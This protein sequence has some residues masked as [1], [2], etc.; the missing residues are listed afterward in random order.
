MPGYV[1]GYSTRAV[2]QGY[3]VPWHAAAGRFARLHVLHTPYMLHM[4][5]PR[6][7]QINEIDVSHFMI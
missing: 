3:I 5:T 1:L 2:T 7:D 4:I 6:T